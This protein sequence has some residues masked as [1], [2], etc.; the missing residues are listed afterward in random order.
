MPILNIYQFV[1]SDT[2]VQKLSIFFLCQMHIHMI[3]IPNVLWRR[4]AVPLREKGRM[5]VGGWP[6]PSGS[7]RA[8]KTFTAAA[9]N[10]RSGR[11]E[12][13]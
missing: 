1:I 13:S 5:P 7:R 12:Y 11:R 3:A 9:K 4:K 2:D 10:V 8:A 6:Y